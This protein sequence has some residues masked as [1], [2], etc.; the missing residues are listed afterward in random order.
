VVIHYAHEEDR[1]GE[2]VGLRWMI[3]APRCGW[4]AS[5]AYVLASSEDEIG[6][7][8]EQGI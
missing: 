7:L 5:S 8:M 2:S 6:S 3:G 4:G 1:V